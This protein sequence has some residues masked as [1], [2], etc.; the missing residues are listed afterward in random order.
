[1]AVLDA[2]LI[3]F[4]AVSLYYAF[5]NFALWV[6]EFHAVAERI[7]T[8]RSTKLLMFVGIIL[9][10]LFLCT[11]VSNIIA[12]LPSLS[13]DAMMEH[14]LF[15]ALRSVGVATNTAY[16]M[17]A[18]PQISIYVFNGQLTFAHCVFIFIAA[19]T[20]LCFV[21]M[22]SHLA[23]VAKEGELEQTIKEYNNLSRFII[24]LNER[25]QAALL[26]TYAREFMLLLFMVSSIR[27]QSP[28]VG[29]FSPLVGTVMT[30]CILRTWL[31][32]LV[33][34]KIVRTPPFD[35][36]YRATGY[37]KV[38]MRTMDIPYGRQKKDTSLWLVLTDRCDVVFSVG[39]LIDINGRFVL[40]V[41]GV[42][43]TYTL[44]MWDDKCQP[45][46]ETTKLNHSQA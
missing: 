32:V 31:F 9:G 19:G 40:G 29:E 33:N 5:W 17:A 8:S 43:A 13:F 41:V 38:T 24:L 21:N 46:P 14:P 16:I 18:V 45:V 37:Y 26:C 1:M 28:Y 11:S 7:M 10:A 6:T 23:T 44:L 27:T 3:P 34:T 30:I 15:L 20:I 4:T 42:L 2:F 36:T 39:G 22:T 25:I 35:S 12:F